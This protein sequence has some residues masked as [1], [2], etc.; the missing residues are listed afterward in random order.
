MKC[1]YC[2][3]DK[4]ENEFYNWKKEHKCKSCKALIDKERKEKNK[5]LN[6]AGTPKII[7][8]EK[9]CHKCKE[10][11]SVSNF[12][13]LLSSEDGFGPRCNECNYKVSREWQKANPEKRSLQSR[14]QWQK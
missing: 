3:Q 5:Q 11:K 12:Y 6:L 9:K 13:K 14:K 1:T 2:N 7:R 4:L 8:T 10:I